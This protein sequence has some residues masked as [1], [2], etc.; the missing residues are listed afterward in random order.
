MMS[1]A[2]GEPVM[3]VN[4]KSLL[5]SGPYAEANMARWDRALLKDCARYPNMRVFDW[6]ARSSRKWFISDG[7]HYTSLGYQHR[8]KDIA[9]ALARAPSRGR[10]E[11]GLR[12]AAAR[13]GYAG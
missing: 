10:P 13:A 6:A 11:P 5:V 2:K 8:A 1:V 4:V 7:I 9:D 3:W 12:R